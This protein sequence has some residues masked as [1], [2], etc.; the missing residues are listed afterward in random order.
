MWIAV[1]PIFFWELSL[2]IYLAVKRFRLSQILATNVPPARVQA[3]VPSPEKHE[4][5]HELGGDLQ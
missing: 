1:I 2:V 3:P 5:H 4:H